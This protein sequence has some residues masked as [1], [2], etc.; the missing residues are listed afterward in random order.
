MATF[1]RPK[2]SWSGA[3]PVRQLA[4]FEVRRRLHLQRF[5]RLWSAT[6]D[7][8]PSDHQSQRPL[9]SKLP[10]VDLTA[11]V[12]SLRPLCPCGQLFVTTS[13]SV[14]SASTAAIIAGT[15]VNVMSA[16]IGL[17]VSDSRCCSFAVERAAQTRAIGARAGLQSISLRHVG[18]GSEL[19]RRRRQSAIAVISAAFN[20][21]DCLEQPR[22]SR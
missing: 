20:C 9:S 13:S 22:V 12:S 21:S 19:F 3:Q 11:G 16:S 15:I 2:P 7:R 4:E 18:L 5:R 1:G 6:C 8:L 14:S 17:S 10:R